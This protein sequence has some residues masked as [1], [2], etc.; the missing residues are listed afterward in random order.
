MS[1][2]EVLLAA[3]WNQIDVIL[4]RICTRDGKFFL[5]E[6]EENF[7]ELGSSITEFIKNGVDT[8]LRLLTRHIEK[9]PEDSRHLIDDYPEI[10]VPSHQKHFIHENRIEKWI[11]SAIYAKFQCEEGRDYIITHNKIQIVDAANT[12]IVC[13]GMTWC[14]G[15]HQFL[16]IKH[17]LEITSEQLTVCF[18]S[19]VDFIR[20]Y[21]GNIYGLTGTLGGDDT[22]KFL[23]ETYD[24]DFVVVPPFRRKKLKVLQPVKL[25]KESEWQ[26]Y[27]I[28][29]SLRHLE[30]G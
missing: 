30:K 26:Q 11:E 22:K 18:I 14:D 3:I 9:I 28:T 8:H 2:L 7:L 12:G 6:S 10:F 23:K 1:Y 5:K 21:K 20:R 4:S 27:V 15:V 16:Q 29:S 24:I 17:G 25:V 19:N 13:N